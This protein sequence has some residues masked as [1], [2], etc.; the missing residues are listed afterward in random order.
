M[1]R[2]HKWGDF[3][4]WSQQD[5]ENARNDSF[6]YRNKKLKKPSSTMSVFEFRKINAARLAAWLNT[7]TRR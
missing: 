3:K 6:G 4:N 7:K 2:T 5:W 1:W